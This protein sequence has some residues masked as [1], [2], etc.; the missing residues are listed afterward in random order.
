MTVNY[1]LKRT[2]P[3]SDNYT[4]FCHVYYGGKK[5]SLPTGERIEL[6]YWDKQKQQARRNYTGSPE[7][8]EFLKTYKLAIETHIR[9]LRSENPFVDYDTLRESVTRQVKGNQANDLFEAFDKYCEYSKPR[10]S[11]TLLTKYETLRR[12][13]KDFQAETA[14]KNIYLESVNII[15]FD[16]FVTYCY[17]KGLSN[18]YVRH[19]VRLLKSFLRWTYEREITKNNKFEKYQL[20]ESSQIDTIALTMNELKAIESLSELSERLQRVKDLFLFQVFT[21]QRFGDVQKL[22]PEHVKN[23]VWNLQQEKTGTK[24]QIPL[25]PKAYEILERYQM[26]L[27]SITNQKLNKYLKELGELAGLTELVTVRHKSGGNVTSDTKRKHELLTTHTARRTFVS[28]AAYHGVNQQVVMA[29]TG[30]KKDEMQ[31]VYYKQDNNETLSILDN[32]FK[33]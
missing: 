2:T 20:P 3:K 23:N 22:K 12:K 29:V 6:K 31:G 4:I 18:N 8:N 16:E 5:F 32:I 19:V 33:N 15:F 21:G 13:L 25:I 30:H 14:K 27:P 17:S 1:Y 10:K 28:L 26:I 7:F 11:K 9:E 24:I